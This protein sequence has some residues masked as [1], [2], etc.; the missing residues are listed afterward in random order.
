MG[1]VVGGEELEGGVVV[2]GGV[3]TGGIVV[4]AGVVVGR[5]V[6]KALTHRSSH[7]RSG[8]DSGAGSARRAAHS[9]PVTEL[10]TAA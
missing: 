8:V 7:S 6:E 9:W 3:V 4:V 2:V 10:D 5:E 1:G